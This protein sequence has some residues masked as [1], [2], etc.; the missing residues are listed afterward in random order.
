MTQKYIIILIFLIVTFGNISILI[1]ALPGET[2]HDGAIMLEDAILSFQVLTN[3]PSTSPEGLGDIN[4]DRKVG[5]P[6]AAF[7]LDLLSLGRNLGK[8]VWLL[9]HTDYMPINKPIQISLFVDGS[10]ASEG[11]IWKVNN[12][13]CA[14]H[15]TDSS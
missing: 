2:N 14:C 11:L 3:I 15:R 7:I 6:E 8:N 5:L 13:A 12:L 10:T 9:P 1:T 4:G